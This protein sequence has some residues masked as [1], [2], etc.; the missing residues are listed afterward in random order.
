MTKQT[1]SVLNS[2]INFIQ[3]KLYDFSDEKID[4]EKIISERVNKNPKIENTNQKLFLDENNTFKYDNLICPV[5]GSHKIIK[6]GTITKNKQNINGK[7]TEFREQQYQCKKCSKKFG[8]SNNPVIKNNKQY[9]QEIIDKIPEIMK[10]GY[11]SLRKISKYFQIFLGIRISHQTIRNWSNQNHEE[12]I[13]NEEF[14]YSGYYLYD[15][16]FLRLNEVRHYRL[17][18]Y[19]AILNVPVSER[20]VRRRMPKN[21]KKFIID[22]TANKPFICLTTD[23]FPMYRNVADEIGVKHQLCIFHLFKTI[24]HK[25]KVHCRRNK[26]NG[27]KK[28]YIYENAQELKNCFRQN[29]KQEAINQF[30]QYLQNYGAILVVLKD[31]I[32]KHIIMHF[33][34]YVE[35]LDDENIEK[36]SNKVENYYRQTNPA[37]IKKLSKTKNGILTFLDFQMQNWTQNHIII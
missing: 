31:F 33:H 29:S 9:L 4:Q 32:R 6:K 1:K 12:T 22:S 37:K 36:T 8:I 11:Q 13:T 27:N 34:R 24:N 16:Q 15:E 28:D 5:C 26:I 35:H 7:T 17:T 14:E 3:L 10:I 25:L 2:N 30:K 23:L 18:L 21:T 19:D 20:I